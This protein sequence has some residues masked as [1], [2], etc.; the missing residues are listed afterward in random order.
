ML[1]TL[2][3]IAVLALLV[4][5]SLFLLVCSYEAAHTGFAIRL[6]TDLVANHV[7]AQVDGMN[8]RLLSQDMGKTLLKANDAIVDMQLTAKKESSMMD[9]WN[10][11][12][13]R[14]LFGVT[15]LVHNLNK[16]QATITA[17]A[18]GTLNAGTETLNATTKTV[19]DA[20]PVLAQAKI[21]TAA[22]SAFIAQPDIEA[23]VKNTATITDQ[24]GQMLKTAN[25]VETKAT[26][27]YLHSKPPT[28]L[29]KF[30]VTVAPFILPIV[31]IAAAL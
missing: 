22:I 31:K 30:W 1:K 8:T 23:T 18:V 14:T 6:D 29:K 16:S 5:A 28:G 15:S 10:G 20:Q 25:A 4:S 2:T 27:S 17:A 21:T 24:A 26:A 9:A 12:I 19:D 11:S 3:S 13:T 7:I